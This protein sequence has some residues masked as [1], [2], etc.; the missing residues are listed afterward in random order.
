M[1]TTSWKAALCDAAR[2]WMCDSACSIRAAEEEGGST[3]GRAVAVS[4]MQATRDRLRGGR[5]GW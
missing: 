2:G 1:A 3:S 4:K 5:G